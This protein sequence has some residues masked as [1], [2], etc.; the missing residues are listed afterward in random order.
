MTKQELTFN[1]LD[2]YFLNTG[3]GKLNIGY[4]RDSITAYFDVVERHTNGGSGKS[5]LQINLENNRRSIKSLVWEA[6]LCMVNG[7][8]E[9]ETGNKK[10]TCTSAQLKNYLKQY[11]YTLEE[12]LQPVINEIS[13]WR[14]AVKNGETV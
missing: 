2:S 11:G 10:Y 13:A 7:Y 1:T 3:S 4:L 12:A 6:F 9:N 8:L 14:E 5:L